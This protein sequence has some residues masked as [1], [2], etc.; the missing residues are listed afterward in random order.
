M[1]LSFNERR[2]EL[3]QGR[4]LQYDSGPN[5]SPSAQE[6]RPQTERQLTKGRSARG[7]LPGAQ[8]HQQR[9]L[10]SRFSAN[11]RPIVAGLDKLCN[12]HQPVC[13]KARKN[14]SWG[15]G[16]GE[17]IVEIQFSKSPDF[18]AK[19]EFASHR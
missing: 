9:L 7:T 14:L 5:Y 18:H 4:G 16:V 19:L 6:Q 8:G 12:R 15:L 11:D 3:E 17:V 13:K 10:E 1:I 2:I